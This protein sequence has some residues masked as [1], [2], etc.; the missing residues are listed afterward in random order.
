MEGALLGKE[1]RQAEEI[2]SRLEL[3]IGEFGEV[4]DGA[5]IAFGLPPRSHLPSASWGDESRA[6]FPRG[7]DAT[8]TRLRW[9]GIEWCP[10]F[11]AD[12]R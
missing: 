11:T 8:A 5:L 12:E 6:A 9:L 3:I 7:L 10:L 2:K 4:T 1:Q